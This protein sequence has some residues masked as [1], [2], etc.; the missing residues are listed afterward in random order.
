M[1]QISE[2]SFITPKIQNR[3]VKIPPALIILGQIFAGTLIGVWGL[4]FATPLVLILKILVEELYIFPM[5]EKAAPS[6]AKTKQKKLP[7]K[8]E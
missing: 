3:L 8:T 7:S 5:Q 4:V 6:L 1:I 2:G